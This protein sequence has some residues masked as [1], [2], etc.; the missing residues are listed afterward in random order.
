MSLSSLGIC[1]EAKQSNLYLLQAHKCVIYLKKKIP[2][3]FLEDHFTMNQD[4]H[5]V[6]SLSNTEKFWQ[7]PGVDLTCCRMNEQVLLIHLHLFEV[8]FWFLGIENTL[9]NTACEN[10]SRIP[11]RSW[12]PIPTREAKQWRYQQ[13]DPLFLFMEIGNPHKDRIISAQIWILNKCFSGFW[14]GQAS[15]IT[16][17]RI[18][19]KPDFRTST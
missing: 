13:S 9:G 19:T 12:E 8:V 4:K 17:K 16:T 11:L 10:A 6:K 1:Q 15:C 14:N 5:R 7:A 2:E 3:N 18:K